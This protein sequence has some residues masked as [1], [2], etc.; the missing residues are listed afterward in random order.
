MAASKNESK[1]IAKIHK[2]VPCYHLKNN[3]P[4]TAGIPDVFYSGDKGDLWV[5][6]K[7]VAELPARDTTI[8][9]IELS[10]L[11]SAWLNCRYQEGRQ[12]AVI[13]GCDRG[14][15]LLVHKEWDKPITRK[16]F[17]EN[18]KPLSHAVDYI[19]RTVGAETNAADY[20]VKKSRGNC[21]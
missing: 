16:E 11:Q 17:V 15:L 3:N 5:E 2:Q 6:Y 7:W 21:G 20:L 19:T 18:L 14:C 4:F 9:P 1:L 12:V 10:A 8:V 13:V